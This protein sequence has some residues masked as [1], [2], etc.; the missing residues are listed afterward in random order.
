MYNI[1]H[2]IIYSKPIGP[3]RHYPEDGMNVDVILRQGFNNVIVRVICHDNLTINQL[4]EHIIK[5][6]DFDF[7]NSKFIGCSNVYTNS[8]YDN[9]YEIEER[10]ILRFDFYNK[11]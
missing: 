8:H 9:D 7:K 10:L 4:Y 11:K 1:E 6:V 3:D 2:T 5:N